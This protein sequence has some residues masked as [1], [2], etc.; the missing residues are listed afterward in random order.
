MNSDFNGSTSS[1]ANGLFNMGF[2]LQK[3]GEFQEV[4]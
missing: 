2:S 4:A 3:Q 1:G